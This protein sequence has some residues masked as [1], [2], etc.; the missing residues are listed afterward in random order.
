MEAQTE[1]PIDYRR[2]ARQV[3]CRLGN[4]PV[5]KQRAL[6]ALARRADRTR[7]RAV[8]VETT[9]P[10]SD[11][12]AFARAVTTAMEGPILRFS[13]RQELIRQAENLGIRRFDANLLIA[14]VQ[15]R[16]GGAQ[17]EHFDQSISGKSLWRFAVPIGLAIGVQVV[18]VLGAWGL[19]HS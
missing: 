15:H 11:V 13:R 10:D 14:A 2:L 4:D 5:G 7:P 1:S 6:A 9:K 12:R 17:I 19:L 8:S 16:M 3:R 18:I